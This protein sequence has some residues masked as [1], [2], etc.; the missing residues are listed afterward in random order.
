MNGQRRDRENGNK[1]YFS[2]SRCRAR[3]PNQDCGTKGGDKVRIYL[4]ARY[5]Q[6]PELKILRS[7]LESQG[8]II[9]S[10]WLDIGGKSFTL[11]ELENE[12]DRCSIRAEADFQDIRDADC[13]IFV[14][15]EGGKGGRHVE[16]GIAL[17]LGKR[18]IIL[19]HRENVFHTLTDEIVTTYSELLDATGEVKSENVQ[20]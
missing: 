1:H 19:G 10:S 4:A 15:S 2:S 13:L 16:Y 20:L 17:G 6:H 12:P 18:I 7:H 5:S 8:H 14:S 11:E 3:Y 9:T